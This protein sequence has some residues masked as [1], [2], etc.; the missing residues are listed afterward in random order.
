M[1]M[2]LRG[3]RN[4][5]CGHLDLLEQALSWKEQKAAQRRSRDGR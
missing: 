5:G 1:G 4:L 2:D 3:D